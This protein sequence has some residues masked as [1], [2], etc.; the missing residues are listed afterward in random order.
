MGPPSLRCRG[1]GAS[2]EITP[3][4]GFILTAVILDSASKVCAA[5][6]DGER[7][8]TPGGIL[9]WEGGTPRIPAALGEQ[10]LLQGPYSPL[11]PVS[12]STQASRQRQGLSPLRLPGGA[13]EGAEPTSRR[14]GPCMGP[15]PQCPD[16]LWGQLPVGSSRSPLS[17]LS[18]TKTKEAEPGP[19]GHQDIPW[20]ARTQV[21]HFTLE[22][23]P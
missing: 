6:T 1:R 11:F 10:C 17:P 22:Q 2:W 14:R 4:V 15:R 19:S 7:R 12:W 8:V 5:A 21:H 18:R 13:Q 3:P 9:M 20:I 23:P 16:P